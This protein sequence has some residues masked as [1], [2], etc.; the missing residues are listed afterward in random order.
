MDE[1]IISILK[2]ISTSLKFLAGLDKEEGKYKS[3]ERRLGSS[4]FSIAI[5]Y[6]FVFAIFFCPARHYGLSKFFWVIFLGNFFIAVLTQLL[7]YMLLKK[8][9]LDGY[10]SEKTDF[11][12]N[13][14]TDCSIRCAAGIL[15]MILYAFFFAIGH[16]EIVVGY[17]VLKTISVWKSD[18]N[19]RKEGLFT[20]VLR[21]STVL[22]LLFSFWA[23][24]FL[25]KF[26]QG[27]LVFDIVNVVFK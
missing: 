7:Q 20:G 2:E 5:F 17:L 13:N 25:F 24:Y 8:E 22:S 12:Y 10:K 16:F 11:L 4:F 19:Q 3:P 27:V 21:I 6:F 18:K 1:S 14:M 9:I 15:E 26:L 23:S